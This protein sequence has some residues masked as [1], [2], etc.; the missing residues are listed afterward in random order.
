MAWRNSNG[1]YLIYGRKYPIYLAASSDRVRLPDGTFI[2]AANEYFEVS[3][4][5]KVLKHYG[6]PWT[7]TLE[8]TLYVCG[9]HVVIA[10]ALYEFTWSQRSF[11]EGELTQQV[12]LEDLEAIPTYALPFSAPDVIKAFHFWRGIPG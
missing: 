5:E 2:N 11:R 9:I 3:P 7:T 12:R 6:S 10:S 1:N 8:D 4:R